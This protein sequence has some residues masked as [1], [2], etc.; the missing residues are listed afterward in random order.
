[1]ENNH[2]NPIAVAVNEGDALSVMGGTYRILISGKDTGGAFAIIDMLIPPGSG[3]GPHAHPD[4]QESF[5]VVQGEV[6]VKTEISTYIARQDAFVSI[7]K[8]GMIHCFKNKTGKV[9]RLLCTVVP[10]GLEEMFLEIGKPVG[11]G[12][13][14]PPPIMTAETAKNMNAIAEKYGQKLYA[15]DFLG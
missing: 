14:L 10:A 11:N 4:F 15:P 5:Y 1:M 3:P 2:L 13:F 6:E 12:E 9:A 7:P 8:G